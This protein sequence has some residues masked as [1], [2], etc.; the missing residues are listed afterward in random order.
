MSDC[1]HEC[2][3]GG[4]AT[5]VLIV[6]DDDEVARTL[7]SMVERQGFEAVRAENGAVALQKVQAERPD[8]ILL[9]I[10]MPVMD[11]FQLL[12]VLRQMPEARDI[13]VIV[14]S[15]RSDDATVSAA[16]QG[17]ATLYLPKPFS[18]RELMTVLRRVIAVADDLRDNGARQPAP[19]GSG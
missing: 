12:A 7:Q 9:D 5:K 16:W 8:V 1:E 14:L 6:D 13:P 17:G 3:H 2:K 10:V 19:T 18:S 11:G 15:V 4:R